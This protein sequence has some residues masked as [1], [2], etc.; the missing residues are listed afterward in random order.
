MGFAGA[1]GT[2]YTNEVGR[3]HFADDQQFAQHCADFFALSAGAVE[4]HGDY[5]DLTQCFVD[6]VDEGGVHAGTPC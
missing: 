4:L 3:V 5:E 1:L 6:R 2:A